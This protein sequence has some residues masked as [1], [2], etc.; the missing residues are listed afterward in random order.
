MKNLW[1]VS[2][3]LVVNC[4]TVFG[5][6]INHDALKQKLQDQIDKTLVD[7]IQGGVTFGF[8]LP[9]GTTL[10]V[11]GG[12]ADQEQQLK[13]KPESRMLG[14]STGKVFYS[15]V[16][17]QLIE[18]GKLKLDTKI[19]TYLGSESWFQRLPNSET[20]TIRNLMRHST[21]IPR[22]V[23]KESFQT[24]IVKDINKVWKPEEL[25]SYVFDDEP[26]FTAGSNFAYSDTNYIVLCMIIEKVTGNDL[27]KEV[28]KRVLRKAGLKNVSPQN[29]RKYK[30]L[31]QGYNGSEDPFYP[32]N[33]LD[34]KGKSRYNLQ[35]EWAGGG[36]V[37]TSHDLAKLGKLI[38]EGKMFSPDLLEEYFDGRDAGRLGGE[39]GLGVHILETPN[40]MSYG[41]SGFMPGYI[42]NMAYYKS[43]RF[44][45]CI[46]INNSKAEAR[47]LM[48]LLPTLTNIIKEELSK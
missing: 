2:V 33:A 5:Q 28:E 41:H 36:L 23:F 39:W 12:W 15:V 27:Y 43:E 16:A 7:S 44:S 26:L 37:I 8:S 38:Y 34:N 13:M 1:I 47:P 10:S 19:S 11:A 18:E 30:G 32:G 35:F 46:Q 14:G 42:T 24:D 17:L 48:R 6:G 29:K 31:T 21:G 22:Y 45:V 25:V 40:G 20:L 4:L 3:L 9:D